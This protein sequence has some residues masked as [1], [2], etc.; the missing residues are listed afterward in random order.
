MSFADRVMESG[1]VCARLWVHA[2]FLQTDL[3]RYRKQTTH[4][5]DIKVIVA[6]DELNVYINGYQK[7]VRFIKI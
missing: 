4:A 7:Y 3:N 1:T 6:E 5:Q 2:F